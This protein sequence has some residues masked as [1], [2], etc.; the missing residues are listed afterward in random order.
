MSKKNIDSVGCGLRLFLGLWILVF[1]VTAFPSVSSAIPA[2]ARKHDLTCTSCHTKPPRLNA[3]GEAF[4]MAGFQIPVTEEG[5]IKKKRKIGRIWSEVNFLNIFSLRTTGNFV[6]AFNGGN[7]PETNLTLPHAVELYLA[8]TVTENI[9][10][11]FELENETKEIEGLDGGL[12]EE[13][14][15]FGL[16]KEFFLMFNLD[17]FVKNPFSNNKGEMEGEKGMPMRGPMV[18]GPMVMVGKIDPSTNFS[19]PTNRQFVLN[20][21][22]TVDSGGGIQRFSLTPY[23]FASK[24]Y[25]MRTGSGKS[26]EVTKSVLYNTTG[27]L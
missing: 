4:H 25:G 10:Y 11:F 8:G 1:M 16:G 21:P 12:F 20:V 19:Y 18:M 7:I 5:Q 27:Y 15:R 13:K 3:F 14:S 17:P 9:S 2:F 6:E 26:V 24:F 23:A 22:G